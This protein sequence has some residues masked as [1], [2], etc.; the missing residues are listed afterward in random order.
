MCPGARAV[1]PRL[2]VGRSVECGARIVPSF[3]VTAM[4]NDG[5]LAGGGE[6]NK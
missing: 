6:S 4:T 5:A 1:F 2:S 3:G